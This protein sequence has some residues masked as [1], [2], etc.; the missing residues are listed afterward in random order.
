MT[1]AT[2][3]EQFPDEDTAR[4]WLESVRWPE[5]RV[6]GHCGSP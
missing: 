1:I 5:G 6:C 3:I 4:R 2:V